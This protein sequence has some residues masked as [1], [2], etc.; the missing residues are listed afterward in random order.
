MDK[1]TLIDD[2]RGSMS[3]YVQALRKSGFEVEHLHRVDLALQHIATSANP[4]SIYILDLMMPPEDALDLEE[5]GFG[6]TSGVEIYRR[7]RKKFTN[8]PV[9]LLTSVSNPTILRSLPLD[10]KTHRAAKIEVLPFELVEKVKMIL[11]VP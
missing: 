7:L 4:S 5:A 8:V 6:L 9:L 11:S 2:D 10:E 3:L 1:I